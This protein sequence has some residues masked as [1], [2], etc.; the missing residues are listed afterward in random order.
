MEML[1]SLV[2][3]GLVVRFMV[4]VLWNVSQSNN[5]SHIGETYLRVTGASRSQTTRSSHLADLD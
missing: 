2:V 3:C 1:L 4:L 5:V